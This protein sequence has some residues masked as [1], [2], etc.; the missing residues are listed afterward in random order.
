MKRHSNLVGHE[1]EIKDLIKDFWHV[2]FFRKVI[3]K[4]FP[5]RKLMS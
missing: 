3:L 4:L 2:S 5:E 1:L